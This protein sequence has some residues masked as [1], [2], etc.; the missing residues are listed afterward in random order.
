MSVG[1][2]PESEQEEIIDE[3]EEEKE[4]TP[5]KLKKLDDKSLGM[6][7]FFDQMTAGSGPKV[8]V[9]GPR[10]DNLRRLNLFSLNA[11]TL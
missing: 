4:P 10:E 3:D 11:S 9:N 8:N 6:N 2:A 1:E 7:D 5:K